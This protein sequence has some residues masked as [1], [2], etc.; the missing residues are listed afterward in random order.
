VPLLR[1][2]ALTLTF[3]DPA[4]PAEK[5]GV[6]QF[7]DVVVEAVTPLIVIGEPLKVMLTA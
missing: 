3:T 7:C 5:E 6:S 1:P 4:T 2:A